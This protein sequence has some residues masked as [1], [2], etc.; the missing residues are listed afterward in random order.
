MRAI[1][2]LYPTGQAAQQA[3]DG[4]CAIGVARHEITVLTS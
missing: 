3:V 2:A 4:L 1:Y